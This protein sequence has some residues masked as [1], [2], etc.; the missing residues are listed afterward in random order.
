MAFQAAAGHGNL[1]NGYF[2][3]TIFS[4][5]ALMEFRKSSVAEDITNT[6]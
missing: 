1:P 6:D 2:S 3:P 5:K 4:K